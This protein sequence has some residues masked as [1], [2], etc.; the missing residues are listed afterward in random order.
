M[1]SATIE[2]LLTTGEW[3]SGGEWQCLRWVQYLAKAAIS[4]QCS[5]CTES[6]RPLKWAGSII[7]TTTD[8]LADLETALRFASRII[9]DMKR[10]PHNYGEIREC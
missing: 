4:T 1:I 3:H 8:A 5:M 2:A 9:A 6:V 10:L 7:P